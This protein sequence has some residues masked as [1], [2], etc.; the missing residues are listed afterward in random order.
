MLKKAKIV[1]VVVTQMQP[2]KTIA[3]FRHVREEITPQI[4]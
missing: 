2:L 3:F 4:T 1:Y